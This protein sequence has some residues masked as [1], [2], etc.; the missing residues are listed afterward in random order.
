MDGAVLEGV[1][2]DK[3]IEVL[4]QLTGDFRR[5]TG[6]RAIHK[7]LRPLTGKAMDPRAEGGRG[8]LERV[9]NGLEALPFDHS[10]HG[11]GTAEDT[12]RFGLFHKGI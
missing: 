6:T 2:V 9:R 8:K 3:T 12:C 4:F 7:P 1:L 11:L 5:T 10:A